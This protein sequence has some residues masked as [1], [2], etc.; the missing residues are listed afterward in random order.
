MMN[1]HCVFLDVKDNNKRQFLQ[2]ISKK[3]A[4]IIKIDERA[5]FD[6]LLE[7]EN[8][9]STGFGEG[10]AIP[11]ARIDG[12]DKAWAFLAKLQSPIDFE[13][14]DNKPVDLAF[15][16]IS[17]EGS[18]ADHLTALAQISRILKDEALCKKIRKEEDSETV[19]ALLSN[20]D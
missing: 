20:I 4:D 12:I 6:A 14:V 1:K 18:G 5:I 11:H 16:L 10:T 7:R 8:L 17:P 9:G 3:V 19:F 13:S 15:F 2:N